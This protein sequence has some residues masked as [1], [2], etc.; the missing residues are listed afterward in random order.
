MGLLSL[1]TRD[2]RKEELAR[3]IHEHDN[4]E[5]LGTIPYGYSY[6][7][8]RYCESVEA[9]EHLK[10]RM[11][12]YRANALRRKEAPKL[13]V[14]YAVYICGHK[15]AVIDHVVNVSSNANGVFFTVADVSGKTSI[16]PYFGNNINWSEA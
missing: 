5:Y 7:T 12:R 13:G 10:E 11:E 2:S 15:V 9:L 6:D 4:Y 16:K 1:F 8:L 3:W 14:S